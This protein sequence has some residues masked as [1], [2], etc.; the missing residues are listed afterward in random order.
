MVGI[1]NL[2]MDSGCLLEYLRLVN[3]PAHDALVAMD[4][5]RDSGDTPADVEHDDFFKYNDSKFLEGACP[6]LPAAVWRTYDSLS[7]RGGARSSDSWVGGL[8]ESATMTASEVF[9]ERLPSG[10]EADLMLRAIFLDKINVVN[11]Q[12][13]N[14]VM[15]SSTWSSTGRGVNLTVEA[16]PGGDAPFPFRSS[17]VYNPEYPLVVIEGQKVDY[18]YLNIM[19]VQGI[20]ASSVY[21]IVNLGDFDVLQVSPEFREYVA[22]SRNT[23]EKI[24]SDFYPPETRVGVAHHFLI[25]AMNIYKGK[26]IMSGR[27]CDTTGAVDICSFG[28]CRLDLQA[29][30]DFMEKIEDSQEKKEYELELMDLAKRADVK[31][32]PQIIEIAESMAREFKPVYI[33][34][35]FM[36][37][38]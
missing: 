31:K 15:R 29:R 6:K 7:K 1:F 37:I 21:E 4:L 27:M 20:G 38:S 14:V 28:R 33:G 10:L 11:A 36:P 22:T 8:A 30:A 35:V 32:H 13:S 17:S 19:P 34:H 5:P 23:A 16:G 12:D 2:I 24:A 18:K 25:D 9:E 3:K 26:H